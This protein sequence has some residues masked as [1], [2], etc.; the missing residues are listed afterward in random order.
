MPDEPEQ[1]PPVNVTPIPAEAVA[2]AHMPAVIIRQATETV[3][4]EVVQ[5][6]LT[7]DDVRLLWDIFRDSQA[8]GDESMIPERLADE[9]PK[10]ATLWDRL[11]EDDSLA[12]AT[13]ILVFLTVLGLLLDRQPTQQSTSTGTRVQIEFIV[14][15]PPAQIEQFAQQLARDIDQPP[16][17]PSGA[18]QPPAPSTP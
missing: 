9:V 10:A 11:K 6:G 1:S 14:Q 15:P 16:Q 7:V 2:A 8:T 3:V 5:M 13:W 17:T 12:M 18:A 4:R